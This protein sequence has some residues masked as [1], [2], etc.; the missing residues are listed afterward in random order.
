ML[1]VGKHYSLPSGRRAHGN[2]SV[3]LGATSGSTG[4]GEDRGA[5]R[6]DQADG[7]W[8]PTCHW[9]FRFTWVEGAGRRRGGRPGRPS[10][11]PPYTMTEQWGSPSVCHVSGEA[12]SVASWPRCHMVALGSHDHSGVLLE[13]ENRFHKST[14]TNGVGIPSTAISAAA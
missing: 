5:L 4:S 12:T 8:G 1:P 6:Q 13:G 2:R 14:R 11:P 3:S 7:G 9:K 10:I